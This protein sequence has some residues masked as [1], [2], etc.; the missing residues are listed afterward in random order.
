MLLPFMR[1]GIMPRMT[2]PS[3]PPAQ[4]PSTVY[5]E[6]YYLEACLGAEEWARS[7]GRET[8]AIYQG[9]LDL[10]GLVEGDVVVDLGTGRGELP[11]VAIENGAAR[12]YGVEYA[13]DAVTLARRT[14]E[15]HGVGDR[16]EIIEAD[17]RRVPLDD[18]IA[19]L[20]MLIDVVEHLTPDELFRALAE[21]RR[22]LR[23]GG[24]VF[25]HTMPNRTVYRWTYRVQRRL[26]G[27]SWPADPRNE[28]EHLMHVNEQTVRSLRRVLWRVGF[29]QVESRVGEIV[30]AGFV[31][32]E[33]AQRLYHR[34]A[35]RRLTRRFGRFDLFA[36][37]VRPGLAPSSA[38]G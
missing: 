30:Y 6:D 37:G 35:K 34:L 2:S 18:G 29:E 24:R 32:D 16:V 31:P 12:A 9:V 8:A 4:V 15:T 5:T 7:D 20:V 13:P 22:L 3:L 14:V 38:D 21:T 28:W 1:P 27:R 33:R 26:R 11:V 36:E 19:D 25:V 23:P 10:A 17:V